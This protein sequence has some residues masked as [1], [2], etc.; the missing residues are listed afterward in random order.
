MIDLKD[1][2]TPFYVVYEDRLRRNLSLIS[3]VAAESGAKIIMA[4]KANA[5]WKTFGVF[6]EYGFCSAASSVNEMRLGNEELGCKTRTYCPVYTPQ[7][8][9]KF[10]E[11]S[12]HITFNSVAQFERFKAEVERHNFGHG[13]TDRVSCGLRIN[14]MCSVEIGR[15][16]V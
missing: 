10:L 5:L 4:F 16:H 6:R 13:E 11:G 12:S 2:E 7:T 9:P 1:I 3:R 14:P 15:A 8:M